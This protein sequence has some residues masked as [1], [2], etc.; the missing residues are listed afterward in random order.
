M[1]DPGWYG[2]TIIALMAS[3]PSIWI[4]ETCTKMLDSKNEHH[5]QFPDRGLA[6]PEMD[7]HHG[8]KMEFRS[9]Q[10][11]LEG[12]SAGLIRNSAMR[13]AGPEPCCLVVNLGPWN[14]LLDSLRGYRFKIAA[15]ESA[16]M[17]TRSGKAQ[18][19]LWRPDSASSIIALRSSAYIW[20]RICPF[21]YGIVNLGPDLC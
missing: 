20:V 8:L 4:V 2:L 7:S 11:H 14:T 5:L 19:Q 13:C 10:V 18:V 16:S 1:I 17:V 15:S 9:V 3:I 12:D 6:G 21:G